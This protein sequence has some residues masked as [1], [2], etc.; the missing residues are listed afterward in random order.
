M[1]KKKAEF[2]LEDQDLPS[3]ILKEVII[4]GNKIYSNA[5]LNGLT[6]SLTDKEVTLYDIN[7]LA[8][9]ITEKYKQDGYITSVAYVPR[10]LFK[11][12]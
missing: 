9:S 11:M 2:H 5:E 8:Q 4:T 6:S 12:E 7:I 1:N 3:F 10:K